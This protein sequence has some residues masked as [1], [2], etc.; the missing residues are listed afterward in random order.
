MLTV[1][2][3]ARRIY[4]RWGVV[5]FRA[6]QASNLQVH[7]RRRLLHI[8]WSRCPQNNLRWFVIWTVLWL[9]TCTS[10]KRSVPKASQR[11]LKTAFWDRNGLSMG[12]IWDRLG[13]VWESCFGKGTFDDKFWDIFG[14]LLGICL[15]RGWY[16]FWDIF[17]HFLGFSNSS[18]KIALWECSQNMGFG[19]L[20]GRSW[21]FP[22][23]VWDMIGKRLGKPVLGTFP[24]SSEFEARLGHGLDTFWGLLEVPVLLSPLL[25]LQVWHIYGQHRCCNLILM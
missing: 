8:D 12:C 18:Q 10:G 22:N 2:S 5:V 7:C 4:A 13:H 14:I 17:Q 11:H 19:T 9:E 25:Y 1:T 24:K 23:T 20:L 6:R 3:R 15:G 21:D 16:V